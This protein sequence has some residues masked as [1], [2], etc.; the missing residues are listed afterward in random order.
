MQFPSPKRELKSLNVKS[1]VFE[2]VFSFFSY[3]EYP[4]PS[5]GLKKKYCTLVIVPHCVLIDE[6]EKKVLEV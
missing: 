6:F 5:L 3:L 1:D 4:A 2:N